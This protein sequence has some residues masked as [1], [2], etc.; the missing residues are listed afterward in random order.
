MMET[1]SKTLKGLMIMKEGG[2][3]LR[4]AL[5]RRVIMLKK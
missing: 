1:D 2:V 3:A 4:S 5:K